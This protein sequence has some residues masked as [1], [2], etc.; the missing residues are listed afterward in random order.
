MP[1][2]TADELPLL[3]HPSMGP[4]DDVNSA[5][6][7]LDRQESALLDLGIRTKSAASDLLQHSVSSRQFSS[8]T[9]QRMGSLAPKSATSMAGPSLA[10]RHGCLCSSFN[11][12]HPLAGKGVSFSPKGD[13]MIRYGFSPEITLLKAQNVTVVT[14]LHSGQGILGNIRFAAFSSDSRF[15]LA[16]SDGVCECDHDHAVDGL[17]DFVGYLSLI[18]HLCS[19]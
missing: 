8:F 11:A 10:E 1:Y 12:P 15:I 14:A 13:L 5:M 17:D 6:S 4:P 16:A 7:P 18:L 2:H 19:S 9:L 3:K